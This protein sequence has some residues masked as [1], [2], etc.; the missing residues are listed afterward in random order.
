[1]LNMEELPHRCCGTSSI[2]LVYAG[3]AGLPTG[4]QRGVG[5]CGLAHS[6]R[7]PQRDIRVQ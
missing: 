7:R 3:A 1:M 6:L 4:A 2:R 5:L